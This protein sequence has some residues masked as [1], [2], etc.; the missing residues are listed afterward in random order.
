SN[1]KNLG[2]VNSQTLLKGQELIYY[3]FEML[4]MTCKDTH[5]FQI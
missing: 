3:Y 2:G 5:L 4:F 1:V